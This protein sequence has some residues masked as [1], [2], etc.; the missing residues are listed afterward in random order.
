MS[1][2]HLGSL[3]NA[4]SCGQM[5]RNLSSNARESGRGR[6]PDAELRMLPNDVRAR[7][8]GGGDARALRLDGTGGDDESGTSG[9]GADADAGAG[10]QAE[11]SGA[12]RAG[13]MDVVR[14]VL[15][16]RMQTVLRGASEGHIQYNL[17]AIVDDPYLCASDELELLKRERV[18][19]ERRLAGRFPDG[20]QD[21]V[22]VRAARS[23]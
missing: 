19:L 3:P 23:M 21:K 7:G 11:S 6:P 8:S 12:A 9:V 22:R 15:Q 17:I 16:R 18:A 2:W 4:A 20:W 5:H 14:P 13:W 10:V 1:H